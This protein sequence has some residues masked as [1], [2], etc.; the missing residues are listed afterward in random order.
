[1]L[2]VYI[3]IPF[4]AKKCPYCDFYSVNY[5]KE[6][7]DRYTDAVAFAHKQCANECYFIFKMMLCNGV[8]QQ[9]YNILRAFQMA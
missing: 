6:L 2:G 1:M 9:H 7:A 5:R 8:L 4:C 3:H